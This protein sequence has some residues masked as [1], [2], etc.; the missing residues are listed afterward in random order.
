MY[1]LATCVFPLQLSLLVVVGVAKAAHDNGGTGS[2]GTGSLV[3]ESSEKTIPV[4]RTA[5]YN[6]GQ[7]LQ[8]EMENELNEIDSKFGQTS[9]LSE[10]ELFKDMFPITSDNFTEKVLNRKDAWIVVFHDGKTTRN[11]MNMA[12]DLR[13]IAWVGMI[14]QTAGMKLLNNMVSILYSTG[15][16]YKVCKQDFIFLLLYITYLESRCTFFFYTTLWTN[17]VVSRL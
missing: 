2:K 8:D 10:D 16:G 9:A 11:W 3:V 13:G 12:R 7:T 15:T 5:A 17:T 6:E 1:T 14:E 4:S